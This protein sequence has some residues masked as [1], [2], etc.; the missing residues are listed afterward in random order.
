MVN[1]N[2]GCS[3]VGRATGLHPVGRRFDSYQLHQ[4][5]TGNMSRVRRTFSTKVRLPYQDA[6][7]LFLHI[8]DYH[9]DLRRLTDDKKEKIFQ[10][11]QARRLK[12]WLVDQKEWI[13]EQEEKEVPEDY[14]DTYWEIEISRKE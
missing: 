6:I 12:A 11:K 7:G 5:N 14:T 9:Y 1:N 10:E 3:S 2:R 13:I 8:I 4:H